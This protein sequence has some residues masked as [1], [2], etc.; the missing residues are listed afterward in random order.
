MVGACPL[1]LRPGR[2]SG[3]RESHQAR[4]WRS[5]SAR[6]PTLRPGPAALPRRAGGSDRRRQPRPRRP[7]R[8]LRHRHRGPAVPGGRLPGARG[9]P[10]RAHGR[11][12]PA[13]R[14]RG[15]GGGVRSLGPRRPGIRRGRRRAG[16]ALGGPGRRGG[17]GGTGAAARRPA[18]RVLERVPAPARP[19]RSL[20]RGLPPGDARFAAPPGRGRD[21][22]PGRV[23]GAVRQ[24]G[25]RDAAGGRV[26]RAGA[27]AVRLGPPLH[28]GRM[29]G[30]GADVRRSGRRSRRTGS[31]RS[32]RGSAPPSTRR[33]AA[34]RC[35]TPRW[36][37]PRRG[38]APPD[39]RR[40]IYV[41]SQSPASRP[42][43]A[44][45]GAS[46]FRVATV[47]GWSLP[48]TRSRASR[49]CSSSGTASPSRPA[50]R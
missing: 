29:A 45:S 25:R 4:S 11:P 6:T 5:R 13:A 23:P 21:Q 48:R 44:W 27:V 10:R 14:A 17:Q 15:R 31:G 22:R 49:V 41:R 34:S 47:S 9:R 1:Y 43:S 39:Q 18:G 20:R 35:S 12:G 2:R 24:G 3:G 30:P 19:G 28:Q 16:L 36:R 8:R 33:A 40:A 38:P 32:W 7:R 42:A 26:R 50:A 37:W 46:R